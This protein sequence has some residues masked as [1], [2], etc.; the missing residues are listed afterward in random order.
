MTKAEL[1]ERVAKEAS[2][3]KRQS[4]QVLQAIL[5]SVQEA[6]QQGQQVTLMGFGTFGVRSRNARKGR[7]PRTGQEMWL[8]AD[9]KPT[10]KAGKGLRHAVR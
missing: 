4:A 10:F 9:R 6:L 8:P 1:V 7:H 3:T 2:I 5:D